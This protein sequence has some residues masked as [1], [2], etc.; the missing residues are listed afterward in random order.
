MHDYFRLL[1]VLEQEAKRNASLSVEPS[2]TLVAVTKAGGVESG[3]EEMSG[4][5]LLRMRTWM[6]EPIDR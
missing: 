5:T 1:S 4:L 2:S 6:Q 3:A